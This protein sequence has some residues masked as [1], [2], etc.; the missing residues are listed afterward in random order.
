MSTPRGYGLNGKSI[1]MNVTKPEE[2]FLQFSVL[3]TNG[4]GVTSVKSN[5]Y[6]EN[7][8]M[9]TS[10][11]PATGNGGF[12]NPNPPAGYAI[13]QFKN[14]FNYFLTASS[15]LQPP[16][17]STSATSTTANNVYIITGL[18]TATLAQWQAAGLPAGF[19]PT[20]GQAFVAKQTATIGGSATVGSPGVPAAPVVS[21]VGSPGTMVSSIPV[22]SN[23]G[24]QILIQ[25]AAAT[26]SST[27]TLVATSPA[28]GAIVSMRFSYDA[29]SVTID[30]L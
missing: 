19:T 25:F 8:F 23:A 27:T 11:T 1:Y 14:N 18:G 5:G 9:H 29:S 24:A 30:G 7:V 4:L 26:N 21:I 20:V 15:I 2:T 28:D 6:V 12:I 3:S 13:V 16:A 17:V 10:T 22:A